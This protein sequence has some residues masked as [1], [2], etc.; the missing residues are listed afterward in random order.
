[1]TQDHVP[2]SD[3]TF[4]IRELASEFGITTRAI[5]FYESKGLIAPR[6][7]GETRIYSRRDRARLIL[8][9]RGKRVG[10]KLKE[11]LEYLDLYDVDP[12]HFAQLVFVQERMAASIVELEDK[13]RDLDQALRELREMKAA[14][15]ECIR[16]QSE[17]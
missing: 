16:A 15:D 1:M 4:T 2:S 9:L 11:I 3:D 7:V 17:N 8:I 10:Y 13:R 12:T 14:V 5:R 6:R